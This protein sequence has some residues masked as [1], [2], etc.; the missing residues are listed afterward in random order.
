MHG[1]AD[2]TPVAGAV[3]GF[4]KGMVMG[5][6]PS[7]HTILL[8][9]GGGKKKLV[10][11]RHNNSGH[12]FELADGPPVDCAI[13]A[14]LRR[15][16]GCRLPIPKVQELVSPRLQLVKERFPSA[17]HADLCDALLTYS[18]ESTLF[19]MGRT[20]RQRRSSTD[21]MQPRRAALLAAASITAPSGFVCLLFCVIFC[22]CTAHRRL[23]NL[24][25]YALV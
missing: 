18:P 20:C 13:F 16:S 15:R 1:G 9:D 12:I 24:G 6:G 25:H 19:A 4:Q 5:I 22:S 11:Q 21:S 14:A 17:T 23:A 8:D 3:V 7:Q 10:L 2:D